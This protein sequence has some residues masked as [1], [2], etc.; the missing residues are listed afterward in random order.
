ME[1]LKGLKVRFTLPH[2]L[3][4]LRMLLVM[5]NLVGLL[6]TVFERWVLGLQP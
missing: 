2:D 4:P 1:K 3:P 6:G 5:D